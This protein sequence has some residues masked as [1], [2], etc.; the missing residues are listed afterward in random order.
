MMSGTTR[1]GNVA[2]A[3]ATGYGGGGH[4]G[5]GFG[6]GSLGG[7]LGGHGGLG[8]HGHSGHGGAGTG[9]TNGTPYLFGHRANPFLVWSNGPVWTGRK[10][11]IGRV[12]VGL[13]LFA[14]L[15]VM[16]LIE[17]GTLF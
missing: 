4:A 9:A 17:N 15:V 7:G 10:Q 16:V 6:G 13:L 12:A 11:T 2:I 3:G 5:G 1:W 14:V 8:A